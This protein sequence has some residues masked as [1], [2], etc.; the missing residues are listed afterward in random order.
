MD[1]SERMKKDDKGTK[2]KTGGRDE[3]KPCNR[4]KTGGGKRRVATRG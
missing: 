2:G 3:V 1:T 4:L